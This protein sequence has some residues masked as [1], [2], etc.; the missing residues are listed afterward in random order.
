VDAARLLFDVDLEEVRMHLQA[1]FTLDAVNSR[2]GLVVRVLLRI[3][4]VLKLSCYC[5]THSELNHV[6]KYTESLTV[7]LTM[8][9]SFA[10]QLEAVR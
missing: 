8:A 6:Q 10:T 2:K 1:L 4:K 3:S 5:S 9:I 7:R